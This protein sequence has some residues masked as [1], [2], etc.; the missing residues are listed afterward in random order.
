M[1]RSPGHL[2]MSSRSARR[3]PG[4]T[5][6][7]KVKKD[8]FFCPVL[9]PDFDYSYRE[10]LL[11]YNEMRTNHDSRPKQSYPPPPSQERTSSKTSQMGS[12]SGKA[13]SGIRPGLRDAADLFRHDSGHV[14]RR[15]PACL[16]G[17]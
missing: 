3:N 2:T 1:S 17:A 9:G 5:M 10:R 15:G 12:R 4:P 11:P 7:A 6:H 16:Y 8:R 14:S 13:K